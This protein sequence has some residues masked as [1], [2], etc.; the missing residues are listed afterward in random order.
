MS[1]GR[2]PEQ[3]T[4]EAERILNSSLFNG[5]LDRLRDGA[6]QDLLAA[7]GPNADLIRREKADFI[8]VLVG[9]PL[10][11]RVEKLSAKD[12]GPCE[13]VDP[14]D[15]A[16]AIT[17]SRGLRQLPQ[18]VVPDPRPLLHRLPEHGPGLFGSGPHQQVQL[19]WNLDKKIGDQCKLI[20]ISRYPGSGDQL[21]IVREETPNEARRRWQHEVSPKSFHGAIIG[22]AQNHRQVT[23]YDVAIGGGKACSDPRF[24]RYL[25]AVADWRL[26]KDIKVLERPSILRWKVFCTQFA[27]YW[28]AEPAPRKELIEGNAHYYSS[29][30][31]P[32]CVPALQAGLP[33]TVVCETVDGRRTESSFPPLSRRA[34]NDIPK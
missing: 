14:I 15:A 4:E 27:L 33:S 1:D 18:E 11:I 3:I 22:N 12:Q 19:A 17:S 31:L 34:I 7:S 23:A 32:A 28:A 20:R 10:A 2:T 9:I 8:N 16:I 6:L 5:A 30:E 26:Q 13:E 29:G 21:Y 25:C 24:Y